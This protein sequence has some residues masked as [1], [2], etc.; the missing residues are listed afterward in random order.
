M[1]QGG[2]MMRPKAEPEWLTRL[3]NSLKNKYC[4]YNVHVHGGA[5]K[6]TEK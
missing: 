4:I 1:P 6:G 2:G 3:A 5:K